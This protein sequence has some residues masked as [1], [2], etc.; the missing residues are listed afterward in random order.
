[1]TNDFGGQIQ[2]SFNLGDMRV[3]CLSNEKEL[4]G[5][6]GAVFSD[7]ITFLQCFA[8]VQQFT[9]SAGS[10]GWDFFLIDFDS[11]HNRE[12]NP[13]AFI[14]HLA[15]VNPPVVIGSSTFANWHHALQQLGAL[16]LHKP[17]TIGEIGL[18]LRKLMF[19]AQRKTG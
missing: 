12:P 17:I 6:V 16:V 5:H 4:L 19:E 11:L 2:A 7:R 1:M 8:D 9:A 15:P 3:L 14:R 13:V 10:G 18:A